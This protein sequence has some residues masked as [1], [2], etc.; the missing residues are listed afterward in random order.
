MGQVGIPAPGL[1]VV[2]TFARQEAA[3]VWARGRL[4][5]SFG[6]VALAGAP[7][8]FTHTAYYA[9]TMGQPLTKQLLAFERLVP[10]DRLAA[11]KRASNEW[12]ADLAA[13]GRFAEARPVN[14]DPGLV[15]LGKFMLATTKDQAHRVYLGD[16][17]F[18]E[19]TLRYVG[20]SFEP[21][22]WTYADYREPAV[23]AF[24]NEGRERYRRLLAGS[25]CADWH[26]S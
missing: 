24:L 17:V 2:A 26:D 7:F 12:E 16:G 18:A 21:W 20:R 5:E 22:P 14:L 11:L 25:G 8:A 15:T 4:E 19:S 3:L 6:P 9:D 23:I 10:L 1:L 13:A